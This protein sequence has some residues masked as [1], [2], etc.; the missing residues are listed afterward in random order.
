MAFAG[1][2]GGDDKILTQIMEVEEAAERLLSTRREIIDLDRRRQSNR[3]ALVGLRKVKA[4]HWAGEA[5][6]S[7][8]ALGNTF[9]CLPLERSI[10]LLEQDAIRF[11]SEINKQRS[12]LKVHLH[13]LNDKE[14]GGVLS[15]SLL[16]MDL[17]PLSREE[18]NA[19][20]GEIFK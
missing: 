14:G 10:P 1:G 13:D 5:A 11:D 6:E 9:I 8:L 7:W 18:T 16:G 19:L 15:K 17:N 20:R 2:S 3:E 4:N 12:D